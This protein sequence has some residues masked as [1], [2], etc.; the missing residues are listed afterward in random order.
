MGRFISIGHMEKAAP[1]PPFVWMPRELE[2]RFVKVAA[3]AP[4]TMSTPTLEPVLM[5]T[6]DDLTVPTPASEPVPTSPATILSSSK[7]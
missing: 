6:V 5:P 1:A 4:E 2:P 7:F 3:S